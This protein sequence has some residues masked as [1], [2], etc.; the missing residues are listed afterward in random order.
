MPSEASEFIYLF[1]LAPAAATQ[2][3][4]NYLT[5]CVGI[6]ALVNLRVLNLGGNALSSL[7]SLP[8]MAKLEELDLSGN[9]TTAT[10]LSLCFG[11]ILTNFSA[12]CHPTR[13]V[14]HA[15]LGT[16]DDRVLIGC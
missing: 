4:D 3:S 7:G 10:S 14:C 5:T 1:I 12:L 9:R 15:L 16:R 13:A 11:P 8:V 2:A 6:K